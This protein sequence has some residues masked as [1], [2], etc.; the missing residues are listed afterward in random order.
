[1][2]CLKRRKIILNAFR[3]QESAVSF[4]CGIIC[5]PFHW[6]SLN[7]SMVCTVL[8]IKKQ[9]QLI[10]WKAFNSCSALPGAETRYLQFSVRGDGHDEDGEAR[11]KGQLQLSGLQPCLHQCSSWTSEQPG[12]KQTQPIQDHY[13]HSQAGKFYSFTKAPRNIQW[14]T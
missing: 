10:N 5:Y 2:S 1:M 3:E 8:W 4:F 12:E 6:P 14:T 9:Q 13:I 11:C 7:W